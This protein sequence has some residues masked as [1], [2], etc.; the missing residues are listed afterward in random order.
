MRHWKAVTGV[1]FPTPSLSLSPVRT[2]GRYAIYEPIGRGGM[3][4]VH[5]GRLLG[6]GGFARTVAI[7]RLLPNFAGVPEF[8]AMFLDEARL[9]GRVR[10]PNVVSVLDVVALDDEVFL[11]FEYVHG[12]SLSALFRA[13]RGVPVAVVVNAMCGVLHGLHAAHEATSERGEPLGLVHRDVSPQ[14]ILLGH[15][16]VA[17]VVDFGIAKA[18]GRMQETAD[19]QLKGKV[20]YMAPEQLLGGAID[21]RVDVF[22]AAVVLWEALAGRKLFEAETAGLQMYRVLETEAPLLRTVAPGVSPALEAAVARGLQ[23][24][25]ADRFPT[26]LAFADALEAAEAWVTPRG[27]GAW[28]YE[29]AGAR[30]D[31]RQRLIDAI[32][33]ASARSAMPAD[34]P[35]PEPVG[36]SDRAILDREIAAAFDTET[37]LDAPGIEAPFAASATALVVPSILPA[38][39]L[40]DAIAGAADAP[41]RPRARWPRPAL[42]G[43]AGVAAIAL[44]LGVTTRANERTSVDVTANLPGPGA[45]VAT[46]SAETPASESASSAAGVAPP[47]PEAPAAPAT[48][49][50]AKTPERHHPAPAARPAARRPEELFSRQ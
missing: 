45:S 27:V 31:E 34:A 17:K 24:R 37:L 21:R 19:G 9:A 1:A 49:R 22:A 23:K 29:V 7:K 39:H 42:F 8:V 33:A 26:A 11:V 32:E 44:A 2:I 47:A 46:P 30:L 14:N 48:L 25:S 16:G 12:E 18:A 5:L 20:G 28:V 50:R 36:S 6:P 35:S 3:A 10:H 40:R 15:D 43:V 13:G 4:T 41:P 38:G